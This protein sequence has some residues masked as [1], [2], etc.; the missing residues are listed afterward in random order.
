MNNEL[1]QMNPQQTG[2]NNPFGETDR[3]S[4]GKSPKRFNFFNII[5]VIF[6]INFVLNFLFANMSGTGTQ[7]EYSQFIKL[8]ES[9][10]VSRVQIEDE[11]VQ[12]S[13]KKDAD[14]SAVESI[15]YPDGRNIDS[16]QQPVPAAGS[17]YTV[18]RIDD[19]SLVERLNDNNVDF[20]KSTPRTG[21]PIFGFI[22]S[23]IVPVLI[24]YLLF[25][26]M[27]RKVMSGMG[28]GMGGI[29]GVGKSKAKEYTNVSST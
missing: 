23:W 18:V 6:L 15:L 4:A 25:S 3:P 26:F 12:I 10:N 2:Q 22:L 14:F 29:M 5:I 8:V 13:L 1:N 11:S 21:S 19:P 16:K 24:M 28:G 27:S 20:Y 17:V 9:G 7:I